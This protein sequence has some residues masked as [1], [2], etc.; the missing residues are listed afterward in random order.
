MRINKYIANSGITSRRKAEEYIIQ[1]KVYVNGQKIT[2]LSKNISENDEVILNGK[3]IKLEDEKIYLVL[4]KPKGYITT[5]NEQ[6]GR[7]CIMDLVDEKFR[8]FPVGRLDMDTEGIIILTNDGNFANELMHPSNEIYK[9]YIARLD[10]DVSEN[11][12]NVLCNGVDIGGYITQKAIVKKIKRNVVSI[13]ISEGKN[14]QIRKMFEAIG[15][16]VVKLKRISIGNFE[17]KDIAIGQYKKYSL[18]YLKK[19]IYE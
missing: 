9:T 8:V 13:S 5:S 6:F 2:D 1:G 11:E 15:K 17:P 3:K 16:K 19:K 10:Y 14:R 4:N 7:K 18:S 12:I